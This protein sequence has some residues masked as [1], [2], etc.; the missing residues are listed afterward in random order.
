MG[1]RRSALKA[2]GRRPAQAADSTLSRPHGARGRL[3]DTRACPT[4]ARVYARVRVRVVAGAQVAELTE[5]QKEYIAKQEAAKLEAA[6]GAVD[7][8]GPTSFF[9]GKS[10][11]D[12][13]VGLLAAVGRRALKARRGKGYRPGRRGGSRRLQPPPCP[14]CSPA[15][16][17]F[18]PPRHSSPPPPPMP[19]SAPRRAAPGWR[20]RATARRRAM[21]PS[22]P[23]AGSTPGLATPRASTRCGP[24]AASRGGRGAAA[25]QAGAGAGRGRGR[26]RGRARLPQLRAW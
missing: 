13:Q 20:R 16:H 25:A 10:D 7:A 24:S 21:P 23:S 14:G 18:L 19:P 1:R 5:E 11:K 17:L 4:R 9:H 12:Y 22:C 26:D 3:S 8:K 6:A 2:V 15:V